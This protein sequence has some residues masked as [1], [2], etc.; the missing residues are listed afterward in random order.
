M[1]VKTGQIVPPEM[2]DQ[3]LE[4]NPGA[5]LVPMAVPP[6]PRQ[7]RRMKVGRN[8]A[9]PCGSGAKFKRCC[10]T[11]PKPGDDVLKTIYRCG[12]CGFPVNAV[13]GKLKSVGISAM[14]AVAYLSDHAENPVENR[15][16]F[17][18][19]NGGEE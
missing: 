10:Q 14:M 6:T 13:G 7:R 5:E 3:Y 2:V 17:C 9:C 19:P 8:E 11:L 18:C 12:W 1:D 15:N 16:G 4:E